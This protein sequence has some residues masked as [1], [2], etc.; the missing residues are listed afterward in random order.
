MS[1]VFETKG[2]LHHHH[3]QRRCGSY[4]NDILIT[5]IHAHWLQN[6]ILLNKILFTNLR[7]F[8]SN[9]SNKVLI[10]RICIFK[11]VFY[12][13]LGARALHESWLRHKPPP[14]K[15]MKMNWINKC[16]NWRSGHIMSEMKRKH[17]PP[18]FRFIV[19]F[20]SHEYQ[21]SI[22]LNRSARYPVV[23]VV[24]AHDGNNT[25]S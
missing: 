10:Y 5:E 14:E 9:L 8:I 25:N 21:F 20:G 18:S 4:R 15:K 19:V 23:L 11:I 22:W 1:V 2:F 3:H 13:Q 12:C 7:C 17:W 24:L 16:I 6:E